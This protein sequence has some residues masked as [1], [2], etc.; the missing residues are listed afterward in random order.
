[1]QCKSIF[2]YLKISSLLLA[3]YLPSLA[4]GERIA[5]PLSMRLLTFPGGNFW[6]ATET[7]VSP[8]GY[9]TYI[10]TN[11]STHFYGGNCGNL[12]QTF[13][14]R[15][16]EKYLQDKYIDQET[17]DILMEF[18]SLG[19]KPQQLVL[20]SQFTDLTEA[21][22]RA[23]F[24]GQL[25]EKRF[26][27]LP[28]E[29]QQLPDG[30]V[31]QVPGK[32][33][34]WRGTLLAT[35]GFEA[36]LNEDGKLAHRALKVPWELDKVL[37]S[38]LKRTFDRS[39]VPFLTEIGRI[40][41]E[42]EGLAGNSQK[43]VNVLIT[44]LAN[45]AR[46]MKVDFKDYLLSAHLLDPQHTRLMVAGYPLRI[47]DTKWQSEIE[48][49]LDQAMTG[50]KARTNPR[51]PGWQ[52]HP[53]TVVIGR[54]QEAF[55]EL[56]L[57]K[58]SEVVRLL[59]K[60]TDGKLAGPQALHFYQ[61]LTVFHRQLLDFYNTDFPKPS[62]PVSVRDFGTAFLEGRIAGALT[63]IGQF[64]GDDATEDL[65]RG[66]HVAGEPDSGSAVWDD[67]S[68]HAV[69]P[70]QALLKT[71][72]PTG[73]VDA[74]KTLQVGNW[75]QSLVTKYP[76]TYVAAVILAVADTMR[77]RFESLGSN[78]QPVLDRMNAYRA[79]LG[80]PTATS[81]DFQSFFE[82]YPIVVTSK[83]PLVDEQAKALGGSP[84]SGM[85]FEFL[86]NHGPGTSGFNVRTQ[87]T[88]TTYYSFG[89]KEL[90]ILAEQF[91]QYSRQGRRNL[92][93]NL[94]EMNLRMILS[95]GI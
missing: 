52:E 49:N 45:E 2:K 9:G 16:L 83:Y 77:H 23:I 78:Y 88:P 93:L 28:P 1:M 30:R 6:E 18:E 7:I 15:P 64:K 43:A 17:F 69:L 3:I 51:G 35:R 8:S 81:L 62:R 22:A 10:N 90:Q 44:Y 29:P 13:Q 70:P 53:N 91:P 85:R 33:R 38:K 60:R 65:L 5:T 11:I 95:G 39:Q 73:K 31:I 19:I 71:A 79:N 32:V 59:N 25:P 34:I 12:L 36:Y 27:Q 4:W 82:T 84:L 66:F 76:K 89:V 56:P 80:K 94:N 67:R 47:L 55:E 57:E 41:M 50:Y 40:H 24:S 42:K 92:R 46:T 72:S 63:R 48:S 87:Q 61:D 20:L 54:M 86:F 21:Q 14:Q 74:A 68:I 75:D 58:V 26:T 37:G